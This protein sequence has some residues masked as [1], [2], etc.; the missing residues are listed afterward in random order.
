MQA[1]RSSEPEKP[2]QRPSFFQSP[3]EVAELYQK[4]NKESFEGNTESSGG[5]GRPNEY[6]GMEFGSDVS[7]QIASY[8]HEGS[9]DI[10]EATATKVCKVNRLAEMFI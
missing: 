6:P 5:I 2:K 9:E 8:K 7:Q 3:E 4:Q 10:I 1:K